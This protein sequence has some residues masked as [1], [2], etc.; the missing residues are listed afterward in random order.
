M[1]RDT[2]KAMREAIQFLEIGATG[3]DTQSHLPRERRADP[4]VR[5]R[6]RRGRGLSV[7]SPAGC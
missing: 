5:R 6:F 4:P 1:G 3:N 7:E 2:K